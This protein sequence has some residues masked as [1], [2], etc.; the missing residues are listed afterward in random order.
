MRTMAVVVI[1]VDGE[2]ALELAAAGDQDP[3]QALAPHRADKALG[4]GVRLGRLDRR[5]DDLDAVAAEDLIEGAAELLVAIVD[6]GAR[7]RGS[8]GE[9]PGEL[10][11][12]LRDPC[13][14][15]MPGAAHSCT[16]RLPS[17][18]KKRT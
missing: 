2:D 15:R 16:L 10:A 17:S 14:A 11:R 3:V 13:A 6:Q 1:D 7:R 4:V 8:V 18:M 9:R 5:S 12:V